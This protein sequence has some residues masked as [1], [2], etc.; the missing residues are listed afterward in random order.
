MATYPLLELAHMNRQ[1]GLCTP[2]VLLE[3]EGNNIF[4]PLSNQEQ[5]NTYAASRF[6]PKLLT[7]HPG[8]RS[9]SAGTTA[10]N[11]FDFGGIGNRAMPIRT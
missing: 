7:D 9:V 1:Q 3:Q 2:C 6:P 11:R 5:P 10:T 8:N 4:M